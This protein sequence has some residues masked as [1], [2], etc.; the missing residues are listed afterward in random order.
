MR[1]AYVGSALHRAELVEVSEEGR[2][3]LVCIGGARLLRWR[4]ARRVRHLRP[5]Q[6]VWATVPGRDEGADTIG[7]GPLH[8][9]RVTRGDTVILVG[10]GAD[11]ESE[12]VR[13]A[14][15]AWTLPRDARSVR[16]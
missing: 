4:V 8:V 5:G 10:R 2:V 14:E 1:R 7:A 9:G 12:V 3:V 16:K 6:Q 15:P 11:G 13:P